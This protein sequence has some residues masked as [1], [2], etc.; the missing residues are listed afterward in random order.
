LIQKGTR[1]VLATA[2]QLGG[3]PVRKLK[4]PRQTIVV[5]SLNA[6]ARCDT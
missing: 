4:S 1:E 6:K 3:A 2:E 5:Q